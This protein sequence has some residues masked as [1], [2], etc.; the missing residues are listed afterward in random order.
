MTGAERQKI[1]GIDTVDVDIQ[2]TE[3]E[4]YCR[5]N[6]KE[7]DKRTNTAFSIDQ[8]SPGPEKP[9]IMSWRERWHG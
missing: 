8:P 7:S 1:F 9:G 4:Q 6:I 5:I 3:G 2:Q